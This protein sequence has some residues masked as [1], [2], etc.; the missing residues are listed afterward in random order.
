MARR[1][2]DAS[3]V[4][5]SLTPLARIYERDFIGRHM[6]LRFTGM[7]LDVFWKKK[8]F[9]HLCGLDCTVP[10]RM[11]RSGRV[12][13]SEAF[14]DAL[15]SG[16]AAEFLPVHA[17]NSGITGDKLEA[18]RLMLDS[19]DSI[20]SVTK[21]ASDDYD[22]FFGSDLWCAGVKAVPDEEEPIDPDA[23]VHAPRTLRLVSIMTR[24]VRMEGSS[25]YPLDG[26]RI[27][28]PRDIRVV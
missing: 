5:D 7:E 17:H 11:Y 24:S 20:E 2:K 12:S 16:G 18:M 13:K 25:A 8:H 3:D 15:L 22:Y 14:F 10:Q 28:P 1:G 23:V 4:I 9:M 27:V 6:I 26:C 21:S 19:P